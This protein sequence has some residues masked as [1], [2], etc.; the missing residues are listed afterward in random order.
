M[1]RRAGRIGGRVLVGLL[2]LGVLPA[3]AQDADTLSAREIVRRADE[4]LRGDTFQGRYRMTVIRP[5]WQR[6]MVF[7]VWSEGT[8]K[9]F[10]RVLEPARDRGVAFLKLGRQMWQYIPRI[11][12]VIKIP[13]SMMM[14][15][16]MGSDFTN[17]D[18]VKE[19]S[20]VEDYTHRLLGRE[21]VGEDEAYGI[22]LLP[23]PE[24]P[25]TWA[26]V[27][28]WIRVDDYIPLRAEYFNERGEHIRTLVFSDVRTL[29]GRRLP[30]RMELIEET[31]PGHRTV[32]VLEEAVFDRPIP[33]SVFTQENLRRRR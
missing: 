12:R 7:E 10:I 19:S 9:S 15:S 11:N 13:P 17:D 4:L 21:R 22:E 26:R 23:K 30:V 16:W 1:R 28:E 29:G 31:K 24:A 2:L 5:D 14:E 3:R 8:E 25:V 18:L 27:V 32:L 33:P 20:I 6:S